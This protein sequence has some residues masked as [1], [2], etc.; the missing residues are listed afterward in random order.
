MHSLIVTAHPSTRGFTHQIAA[1][2]AQTRR[3]KG[4][5]ADILNLYA[6]EWK[7]DFLTF[8]TEQDVSSRGKTVTKAQEA[9]KKAD[10]L[11]F[12]FPLWWYE[13]PAILKNFL[14]RQFTSG[15]AF[16]YSSRGI[17][18]LLGPRSAR[19]IFTSGA[20]T[21]AYGFRLIPSVNGFTASLKS[22]GLKMQKKVV[23]GSRRGP[24][25]EQEKQ[26]LT[27]VKELVA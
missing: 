25:P 20:P 13:V 17:T 15:F 3:E 26:W 16:N 23:F 4:G 1:T 10:E 7:E 2:Y 14:D 12:V 24:N 6:P 5:T 22:C 9:I 8:E 18:G 21:F 27:T 19:I 11:V